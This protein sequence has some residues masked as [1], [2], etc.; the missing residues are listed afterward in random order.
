MQHCE[1]EAS[2]ASSVLL[3]R[4]FP[5]LTHTHTHSLSLSFLSFPPSAA[6]ERLTI[7][8]CFNVCSIARS[9]IDMPWFYPL[10]C[11]PIPRTHVWTICPSYTGLL[12]MAQINSLSEEQQHI[13]FPLP[14][15]SLTNPKAH[16]LHLFQ[17]Q[18]DLLHHN[19]RIWQ[20]IIRPDGK[21]PP[22]YLGTLHHK[23][24]R[25]SS[26]A[27]QLAFDHAFT[28]T[29]SQIFCANTGDS[30]WCPY[31]DT[32]LPSTPPSPLSEQAGFDRLMAIQHVN[33]CSTLSPDPS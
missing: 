12:G 29:Y 3:H 17:D 23:D 7:A 1:Q 5:T 9:R 24:C 2:S 33:P 14:P 26:S 11:L 19:S 25:T 8:A 15:L 31:H 21:P 27:V 18:Y 6:V 28:C 10:S 22:F 16:L 13:V 30:L 20:S 32:P 4:V